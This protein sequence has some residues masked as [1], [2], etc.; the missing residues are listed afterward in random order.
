MATAHQKNAVHSEL[1]DRIFSSMG[2]QNSMYV[3]PRQMA[4]GLAAGILHMLDKLG[5]EPHEAHSGNVTQLARHF[6]VSKYTVQKA[7]STAR[8][9]GKTAPGTTRKITYPFA[10][11]RAALH[12]IGALAE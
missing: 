7:L 9:R 2:C 8:V 3:S 1:S 12:L 6:N 5:I 11:V 4:E 10:D